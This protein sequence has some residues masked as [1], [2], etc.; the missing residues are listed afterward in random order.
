MRNEPRP[1]RQRRTTLGSARRAI[2]L[3]ALIA[4]AA[5]LASCAGT[6]PD[7][8]GDLSSGPTRAGA[9]ARLG[10]PLQHIVLI[11]LRDPLDTAALV[12]ACN[13]LAEAVPTVRTAFAGLHEDIG[14]DTIVRDYDVCLI[15]GFDSVEG[16]RAYLE[17]P[18]HI[19]MLQ[20]W[21]DRIEW[22]RIHDARDVPP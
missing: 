20:E 4:C 10:A 22:L 2:D 17:H 12:D 6:R 15:V 3:P 5:L 9:P 8:A 11:R 7:R 16:Y 18:A 1:D 13:A 21:K 19:Q 14:R